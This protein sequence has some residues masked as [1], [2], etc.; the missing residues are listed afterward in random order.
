MNL[1]GLIEKVNFIVQDDEFTE[2]IVK[3]LLNQGLQRIAGGVRRPDS[4][5]LTQPFPELYKIK[6]ITT[7]VDA[8]RVA[9][10][11]DY[12]RGVVMACNHLNAEIPIYDSFQDFVR[13]NPMMNR[14]GM[15]SAI[16]IKGRYLYYN[17][18][19][20]TPETIAIHYHRYPATMVKD[21]DVP[22]GL[23]R[24]FHEVLLVNYVCREIYRLK[25]DGIDGIDFNTKRYDL[26][27][28]M[29]LDEFDASIP[30]DGGMIR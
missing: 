3:D 5:I 22:D 4:S 13:I 29:A 2:D 10:P 28:Q 27:L 17:G 8:N 26:L 21:T 11:I 20:D 19:P 18:I 23:P 15:V 9:L 6:P 16:G 7:V 24:E 12:Q 14:H 30:A 1:R 25:E